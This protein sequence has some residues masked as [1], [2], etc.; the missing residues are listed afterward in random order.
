MHQS[1][2]VA[3]N[4]INLEVHRTARL[5]FTEHRL[6]PGLGND[7][8]FEARAVHLIHRQ[9]GAVDANAALHGDVASQAL[10]RRDPYTPKASILDNALNLPHPVD[11][12]ADQ[13]PTEGRLKR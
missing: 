5:I 12:A 8:K 10:W 3:G 1:L 13:V 4:D 6:L 7:G 9:A 2:E 11:V